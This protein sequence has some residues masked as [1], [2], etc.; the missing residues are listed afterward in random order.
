MQ[1]CSSQKTEAENSALTNLGIY[2]SP[3]MTQHAQ[4]NTEHIEN[5]VL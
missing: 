5:G 1:C 4:R 2:H 3:A